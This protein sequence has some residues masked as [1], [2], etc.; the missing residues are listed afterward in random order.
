MW[1]HPCRH[2][3]RRMR[4]YSDRGTRLFRRAA[5]IPVAIDWNDFHRTCPLAGAGGQVRRFWPEDENIR[6]LPHSLCNRLEDSFRRV[7]RRQKRCFTLTASLASA[8]TL[9]IFVA[10]FGR[11][12]LADFSCSRPA[13]GLNTPA[14]TV[15][16]PDDGH[17]SEQRQRRC[18]RAEAHGESS[19]IMWHDS[20]IAIRRSNIPLSARR[21]VGSVRQ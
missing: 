6:N 3:G 18:L 1:V 7:M 13:V 9:S 4:A 17:A 11:C 19:S 12:L 5:R 16:T 21:P 10:Y 14:K 15:R 8:T 2:A 20:P